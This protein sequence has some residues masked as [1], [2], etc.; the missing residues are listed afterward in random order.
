MGK[1][2]ADDAYRSEYCQ[3]WNGQRKYAVSVLLPH[4][5]APLGSPAFNGVSTSNGAAKGDAASG[6]LKAKAQ[7]PKP[8]GQAKAKAIIAAVMN[9]ANKEAGGGR[10]WSHEDSIDDELA[11]AA[12]APAGKYQPP[13]AQAAAAAAIPLAKKPAAAKVDFHKILSELPTV[14]YD[15]VFVPP[16]TVVPK[17]KELSAAETRDKLREENRRKQ[18][19]AELRK[20]RKVEAA[21]RKKQRAAEMAEQRKQQVSLLLVTLAPTGHRGPIFLAYRAQL[22]NAATFLVILVVGINH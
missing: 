6:K 1:L 5:C 10:Q 15:D 17:E 22:P 16:P 20:Q 19:E 7:P 9:E 4:T 11:P 12:A 13:A 21:A 8:Q 2:T 18:E 14:P 3:L